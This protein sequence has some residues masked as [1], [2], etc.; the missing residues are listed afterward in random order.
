[1]NNWS[2]YNNPAITIPF[3]LCGSNGV[4]AVYYGVDDDPVKAG[5]NSL[6]G[7]NFDIDRCRGFPVMHARIQDFQGSGYRGLCGWIQIITSDYWDSPKKESDPTEHVSSMDVVPAM[8]NSDLPFA[9]FGYFPQL[10]DAPCL[11]LGGYAHLRW[12]AD[13]FLATVPARSREEEITWCLGFR[14]GYME[15]NLPGHKPS[16]LPLERTDA[17]IWNS[18]IPFLQKENQHWSFKQ[19]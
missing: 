5:L 10:F 16:L 12:T 8:L 1:M 2:L 14:W 18:H 6:P 19:A 3:H 4:A 7:L 15:D 17:L 13:T 11:N 9:S